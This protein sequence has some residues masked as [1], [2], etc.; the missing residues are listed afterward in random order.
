MNGENFDTFKGPVN[1]EEIA[2]IVPYTMNTI[3][4]LFC[5]CCC[6]FH[7]KSEE[8]KFCATI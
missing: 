4:E 7:K 3:F 5:C 2:T 6:Y 1:Q 8:K